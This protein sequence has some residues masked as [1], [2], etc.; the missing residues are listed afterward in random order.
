M[1]TDK[2]RSQAFD[3]IAQLY[4]VARPSYPTQLIEDLVTLT[5][6]TATAQ[7]LEVGTGTGKAT[8]PLAQRGYAIQCLEPGSHLT[9]I[10][11]KN[12]RP[13]PSVKVETT[14]FEDWPLQ[15]STYDLVMSAQAFHW[16]DP[17]VGYLK[18]AQALKPTGSLALIWN[19]AAETETAI[20]QQLDQIYRTYANWRLKPIAAR[21]EEKKLALMASQCFTEPVVKQYAWSLHYTTEQYLDLVRTQSDYLIQPAEMQRKLLDAIATAIEGNGG[22][23]VRPYVSVLLLARTNSPNLIV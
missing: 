1:D 8:L 22:F 6:L 11:A 5:Q 14:T 13:Y 21:L 10:A 16:V 15:A 7:I 2:K 23:I 19:L 18:A 17:A 9:A 20:A 4:D 3:Q 12:L